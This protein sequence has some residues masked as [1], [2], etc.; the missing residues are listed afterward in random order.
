[1]S[2]IWVY[3]QYINTI[4]ITVNAFEQCNRLGLWMLHVHLKAKGQTFFAMT[5]NILKKNHK[6]QYILGIFKLFIGWK[7][8]E[9][10]DTIHWVDC[11]Y[12]LI[13]YRR[14]DYNRILVIED[15][16]FINLPSLHYL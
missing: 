8:V 15:N 3:S 6:K 7:G 1:L 16:A 12:K 5:F 13:I 11:G 10:M 4:H 9:T 14:L 2:I